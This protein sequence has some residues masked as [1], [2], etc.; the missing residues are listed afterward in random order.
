MRK[1]MYCYIIIIMKV[2]Q[3]ISVLLFIYLHL[4]YQVQ[5]QTNET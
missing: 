3:Y 4:M 2:I 5:T 1:P